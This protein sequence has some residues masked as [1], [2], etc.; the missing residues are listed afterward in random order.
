MNIPRELVT[1]SEP[2]SQDEYGRPVLS[3]KSKDTG[4]AIIV[5]KV[6]MNDIPHYIGS[7]VEV[8]PGT[9]YRGDPVFN[10]FNSL[11]RFFSLVRDDYSDSGVIVIRDLVHGFYVEPCVLIELIGE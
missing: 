8:P 3:F 5:T 10:A 2:I 1:I 6:V 7:S 4:K 9:V 11:P